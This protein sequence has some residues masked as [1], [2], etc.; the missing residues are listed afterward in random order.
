[1]ITIVYEKAVK[2]KGSSMPY[3]KGKYWD[4]E[5]VDDKFTL[6]TYLQLFNDEGKPYTVYWLEGLSNPLTQ[7]RIFKGKTKDNDNPNLYQGDSIQKQT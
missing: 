6:F 4:F 2:L 5:E 7:L 3:P 1:M